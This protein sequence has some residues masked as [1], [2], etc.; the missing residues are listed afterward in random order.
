[1]YL[2]NFTIVQAG[3]LLYT[4]CFVTENSHT[5]LLLRWISQANRP[6]YLFLLMTLKESGV[7]GHLFWGNNS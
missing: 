3:A 2:S 6:C 4:Q 5:L 1:M 7:P